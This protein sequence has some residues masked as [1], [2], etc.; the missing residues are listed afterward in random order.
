M[1]EQKKLDL[2]LLTR[3]PLTEIQQLQARAK[4]GDAVAQD[5]LGD[6]YYYGKGVPQSYAEAVIW[7][8]KAAEQGLA[9]AQNNLGDCYFNGTYFKR[10]YEQ[11]V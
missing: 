2:R 1:D 11:A 6:C 7:Y 4:A 3:E 5:R 10:N 9:E 8:H